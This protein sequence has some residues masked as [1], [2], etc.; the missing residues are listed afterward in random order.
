MNRRKQIVDAMQYHMRA[1]HTTLPNCF[2]CIVKSTVKEE[3][4]I[5]VDSLCHANKLSCCCLL[6]LNEY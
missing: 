4:C 1:S 3:D 5:N 6:T 2:M